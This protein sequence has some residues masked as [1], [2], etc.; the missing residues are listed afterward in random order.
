MDRTSDYRGVSL[1]RGTAVRDRGVIYGT[2][3][4]ADCDRWAS[5]T[6]QFS[7]GSPWQKGSLAQSAAS[8][9]I[10]SWC[11]TSLHRSCALTYDAR[12]KREQIVSSTKVRLRLLNKGAPA[13]RP[14][15]PIGRIVFHAL[16]GG[17]HHQYLRI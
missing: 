11:S 1:K 2:L 13:S 8:G 6:S 17:L 10:T 16:V 7:A 12:R 3:S 4:S 9:L 15:Q 14:I 5:A